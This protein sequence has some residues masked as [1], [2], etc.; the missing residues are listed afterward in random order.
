M[1]RKITLQKV[2]EIKKLMKNSHHD[3]EWHRVYATKECTA[4]LYALAFSESKKDSD[5][6]DIALKFL[7]VIY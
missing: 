3:S 1:K 4:V 5:I 6:R 2:K 7:A